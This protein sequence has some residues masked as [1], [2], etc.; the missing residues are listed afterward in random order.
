MIIYK[1]FQYLDPCTW[2]MGL[3]K[4]TLGLQCPILFK[5]YLGQTICLFVWGGGVLSVV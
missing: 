4:Q 1:G 2:S 3:V 5:I